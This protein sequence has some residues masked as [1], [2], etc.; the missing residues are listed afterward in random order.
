MCGQMEQPGHER[1][2][3]AQGRERPQER[4][5]LL[6]EA[7]MTPEDFR[8]PRQGLGPQREPRSVEHE[9]LPPLALDAT[10]LLAEKVEGWGENTVRVQLFHSEDRETKV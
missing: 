4:V 8:G 2:S 7:G 5:E 10:Q 3:W 9:P 1:A 6:R